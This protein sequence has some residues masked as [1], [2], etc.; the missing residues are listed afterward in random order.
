M[1]GID[2]SNLP[3]NTDGSVR[4]SGEH[5][6]YYEAVAKGNVFIQTTTPLGLAIP[7]YTATAPRVA[8]FNPK[9]SGVNCS[10]MYIANNKVSGTPTAST[11]GLMRVENVG[12]G[13]ATGAEVSVMAGNVPFNALIGSGNQSQTISASSGTVTTPAG[14]AGDFFYSLFHMYAGVDATAL[15]PTQNF[16]DFDGRVVVPPGTM[17]WLAGDV[18]SVALFATT[19]A[20][21][22]VPE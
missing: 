22:E 12:A 6:S 4:V 2:I 21:E 15:A 3:F 8:L 19:L 10:L 13:P 5:G 7:I 9:G 14:V 17:I 20:W 18:A 11:V 1:A 16:H